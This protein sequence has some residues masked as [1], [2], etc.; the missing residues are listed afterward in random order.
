MPPSWRRSITNYP[1]S[2]RGKREIKEARDQ[3][4]QEGV[5]VG[6]EEGQLTEARETLHRLVSRRF[7]S[8]S[9][10]ESLNVVTDLT[11]LRTA[12]D[13]LF[14]ATSDQEAATV[15]RTITLS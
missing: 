15:L 4:V 12:E 6:R 11:V 1:L 7:P 13:A 8:L 14:E 5:Q 10:P 3:G 9:I 2:A